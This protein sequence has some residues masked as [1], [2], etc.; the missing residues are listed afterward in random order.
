VILDFFFFIYDTCKTTGPWRYE[1]RFDVP[2]PGGVAGSGRYLPPNIL[3]SMSTSG[4]VTGGGAGWGAGDG[5]GSAGWEGGRGGAEV[6]ERLP[7]AIRAIPVDSSR[8]AIR[9]TPGPRARA[10]AA[11]EVEE[12]MEEER[13]QARRPPRRE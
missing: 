13:S 2:A 8:A 5:A 3:K 10:P 4:E 1:S 7:S 11:S 12:R 6:S 9:A